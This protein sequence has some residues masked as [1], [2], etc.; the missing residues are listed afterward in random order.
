M[1]LDEVI[2]VRVEK[3]L[4]N[5]IK[6]AARKRG[7]SISEFVREAAVEKVRKEKEPSKELETS[8]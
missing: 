1:G 2:H 8:K 7:V 6:G 5:E 3:E 4:H